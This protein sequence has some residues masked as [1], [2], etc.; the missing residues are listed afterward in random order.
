MMSQRRQWRQVSPIEN[1]MRYL[2]TYSGPGARP[3]WTDIP[4]GA[5]CTLYPRGHMATPIFHPTPALYT[6]HGH[7]DQVEAV[8]WSPDGTRIASGGYDKTALVW[9]AF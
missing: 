4:S 5:A 7:S 3:D 9:A 2:T 8:A 1:N 6:Y